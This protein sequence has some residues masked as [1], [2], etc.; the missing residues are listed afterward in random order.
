M[1]RHDEDRYEGFSSGQWQP[2]E[3]APKDGEDI[4]VHYDSG[5]VELLR[6]VDNECIWKPYDGINKSSFGI[7]KPTHWMFLPVSPS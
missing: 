1:D 2:I 6:G 7:S 5:M 4:L 3:T